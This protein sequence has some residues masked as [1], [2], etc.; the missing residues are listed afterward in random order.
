MQSMSSG[1]LTKEANEIWGTIKK[2]ESTGVWLR[3]VLSLY[4]VR[5][6]VTLWPYRAL[7]HLHF[8][9]CVQFY[10]QQQS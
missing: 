4:R 6:S 9:Q 2:N 10:R 1:A 7:V 8:E 5:C 3:T